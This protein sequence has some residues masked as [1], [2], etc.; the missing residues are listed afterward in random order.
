MAASS[1]SSS[2]GSAPGVW[3][4]RK[5]TPGDLII[6]SLEDL[7]GN[8]FKRF[9]N[10]L[11]DFYYGDKRPIP[12]G[13]LENADWITTKDILINV[14]G[15]EGAL[16]VTIEVFTLIDLRGPAND[17]RESRKQHGSVPDVLGKGPQTPGDL[18]VYSLED[19]NG[20]DFKRFRNKL[21][22]FS[23]GDTS[24]IPRGKLEN[25][26]WITTK[27]ILIDTYGEER[28]LDVTIHVFTLI[29]L[30]GPADDLQERRA[31]HGSASGVGCKR[32]QEDMKGYDFYTFNNKL[33][34]FSH[35]NKCPTLPGR[36][37]NVDK[38][39]PIDTY[40]KKGALADTI[41]QMVLTNDLQ[42][43]RAEKGGGHPL[44]L[45]W[46]QLIQRITN[47]S[48]V[49]DCLLQRGLLTTEQYDVVM[50]KEINQDKMRRLW[51]FTR[52]WGDDDKDTV[53]KALE[54]H[55]PV[56]MRNLEPPQ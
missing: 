14:Y 26:D 29:G 37:E 13:K 39:F 19:L 22:E 9:R 7:K 36:Q 33:Y 11:S 43:S 5:Q 2:Q 51:M 28:A 15:E 6:Y 55:N 35:G 27:D 8:D 45:L 30:M 38:D 10:K 48:P 54:E 3:R 24:P 1:S 32:K 20:S 34:D 56:V 23:Y 41:G 47:V 31:Q 42:E 53:Y 4:K 49:L 50:V 18:I 40:R 44:D 21:S 12:R 25:A 52:G 17:L 16:D 46:E